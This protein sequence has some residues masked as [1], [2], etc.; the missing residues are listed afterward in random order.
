MQF[1]LFFSEDF[2]DSN[3]VAAGRAGISGFFKI[4]DGKLTEEAEKNLVRFQIPAILFP[5]LRSAVSSLL[6]NAGFLAVVIPLI[7]VHEMA[8]QAGDKIL[9]QEVAALP[10]T[11]SNPAKENGS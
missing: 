5:F 6:I 2:I 10:E 8:S 9:I 1:S 3:R 7:N 4:I 11:D